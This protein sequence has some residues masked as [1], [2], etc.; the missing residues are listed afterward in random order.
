MKDKTGNGGEASIYLPHEAV[1]RSVREENST[2]KTFELELA[3]PEYGAD[4]SYLPGQFVMLSV[5]DH[6]EAPISITS[7]PARGG[8]IELSVRRAGSLTSAL[9]AMK[10]GDRVGIRGPY[11][12]PFPVEGLKGRDLVFVA[13]GIGLA[14]LRC[15]INYCLDRAGEYGRITLLYGSRKPSDMAFRA[16]LES[17]R[18]EGV[19]DVRLTVDVPEPGWDGSVGLV[20]G[21]VSEVECDDSNTSALLCGP[22]VML[23]AVSRRLHQAGLSEKN[24]VMT[25]ERNM[26]CGIGLCGH[27]FMEGVMVCRQGPVFSAA[28]LRET[29]RAV[30]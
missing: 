12:R 10:A 22:E 20:T 5:R 30:I 13:G 27:C 23:E 26:K 17:W 9:H 28:E 4:F 15:M 14:P 21:L 29:G 11:G 8:A 7:A 25:M 1:I 3:E 18:Q 19:V 24:I 6:G 16:D 2:I